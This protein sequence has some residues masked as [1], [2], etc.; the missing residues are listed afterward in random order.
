MVSSKGHKTRTAKAGRPT[1]R[2]TMRTYKNDY[3][4]LSHYN[5]KDSGAIGKMWESVFTGKRCKKQD[6][7]D[8]YHLHKTWEI[9]QGAGTLD[10][11]FSHKAIK[12]VLY[13][14]VVVVDADGSLDPY[15]QEAFILTRE[16][17][18]QAL[19]EAGAIRTDKSFTGGS[20]GTAIQTFWNRSKW[21][22]HGKL[23]YRVLDAM[24]EHCEQ[25]LED[26]LGE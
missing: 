10:F 1:E 3:T 18:L 12:Y 11:V 5:P 14:P 7:F 19:E 21:A 16:A 4:K 26:L 8:W 2:D 13:C 20:R 25:T 22:P 15:K 23:L 9:K 6:K 17:F 24:Y